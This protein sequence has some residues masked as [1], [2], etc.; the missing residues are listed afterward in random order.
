M[1]MFVTW[2]IFAVTMT[3]TPSHANDD[4]HQDAA[5]QAVRDGSILPLDE[6][7]TTVGQQFQGRVMAVR[8]ENSRDGLHGWIYHMRILHNDGRLMDVHVDAGTA[9]VLQ[10]GS[11]HQ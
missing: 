10:V 7:L 1:R 3:L 8:L 2:M 9:S 5:L 11:S 4:V 6:I